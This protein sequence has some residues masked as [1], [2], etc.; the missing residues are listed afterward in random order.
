MIARRFDPRRTVVFDARDV[1]GPLVVYDVRV[2][3][4]VATTL[5]APDAPPAFVP[6][7]N[8]LRAGLLL[9][10]VNGVVS[11]LDAPLDATADVVHFSHTSASVHDVG[12]A[13]R[14]PTPPVPEGASSSSADTLPMP[15][16]PVPRWNRARAASSVS[17]PARAADTVAV[18]LD[19]AMASDD[20]VAVCTIFDPVRQFELSESTACRSSAWLLNHALSKATHLGSNPDGRVINHH[21]PG[22]PRPQ[23]CVHSVVHANYVVIPISLGSGQYCTLAIERSAS[24]YELFLLLETLCSVPRAHRQLLARGWLTLAINGVETEDIF[25]KNAFLTADSASLLRSPEVDPGLVPD[26][27]RLSGAHPS[28]VD[29]CLTLHRPAAPPLHFYVNP[30]ATPSDIHVLLQTGGPARYAWHCVAT[31]PVSSTVF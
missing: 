20:D 2:G 23:V 29:G 5:L 12:P 30:Y 19:R 8:A 13:E 17:A 7:L 16:Q 10:R 4:T 27:L 26:V 28:T 25:S 22:L 18:K 24:V 11:G 31:G 9:C 15:L 14:P 6:I 21:L 3:A 1:E